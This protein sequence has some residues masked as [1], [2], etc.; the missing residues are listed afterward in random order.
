M[1]DNKATRRPKFRIRKDDTVVVL[2]GK[3]RGKTGR[4]VRIIAD[5][6]RVVVEG[7]NMVKRH[8]RGTAEQPGRI[9]DREA[10]LHISN[11]AL[12][13]A[14]EQK[15][16]KIGWQVHEDGTRVRVDRK[17]GTSVGNP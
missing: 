4:V 5:R 14:A 11:V 1:A 9:E 8:V 15:A 3:D 10:S 2:A 7:V 13:D 16:V 6:N 17:S 12:W